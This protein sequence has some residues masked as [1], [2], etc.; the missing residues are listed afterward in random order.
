MVYWRAIVGKTVIKAICCNP[1][2]NQTL[3]ILQTIGRLPFFVSLI[4]CRYL[5][6]FDI[7]LFDES[8][9][10]KA[11]GSGGMPTLDWVVGDD[12]AWE[13][14]SLQEE[15]RP[16]RGRPYPAIL[17][18]LTVE[19][20][21]QWPSQLSMWSP[22]W[23]KPGAQLAQTCTCEFLKKQCPACPEIYVAQGGYVAEL[24][25]FESRFVDGGVLVHL[26][27]NLEPRHQLTIVLVDAAP[28]KGLKRTR[29]QTS[30]LVF[31]HGGQKCNRGMLR[32]GSSYF[33]TVGV[34]MCRP[35]QSPPPTP[36][37]F[38]EGLR[39]YKK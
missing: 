31:Q 22:P 4:T 39:A 14:L 23:V 13:K 21:G 2:T 1:S 17:E 15:Y 5:G 26:S 20:Q 9:A 6:L 38:F 10:F 8:T 7:R 36:I 29:P 35:P 11:V 32:R 19:V 28:P 3:E 33:S 27:Q 18:A 25:R 37:S 24:E 16:K 34:W 12:I 30:G